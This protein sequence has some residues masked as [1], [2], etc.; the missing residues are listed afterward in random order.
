M[1]DTS[2]GPQGVHNR[3]VPLYSTGKETQTAYFYLMPSPVGGN[4]RTGEFIG[5]LLSL[6][7]A[8]VYVLQY[9]MTRLCLQIYPV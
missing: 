4:C 5:I 8:Q 7:G 6:W 9:W 1:L 2:P 3:G